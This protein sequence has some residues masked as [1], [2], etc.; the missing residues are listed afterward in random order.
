VEHNGRIPSD[1]EGKA[2][3]ATQPT[4]LPWGAPSGFRTIPSHKGPLFNPD[5]KAFRATTDAE[6][7]GIWLAE[8]AGSNK[9]TAAAYRKEVERLLLWLADQG[10]TLSDASREDYVRF[11]AFLLDPRPAERW[12]GNK[13]LPRSN[14]G[15]R[16]FQAPLSNGSAR[17]ALTICRSLISYL[18]TNG[19]LVANTMPEPKVL[20]RHTA[21]PRPEQIALRQIP[22]SLMAK[23]EGF[24]TAY[25]KQIK[26]NEHNTE[27][28]AIRLRRDFE[29]RRLELIIALAGTMGARSSDLLNAMTSNIVPQHA[30]GTTN[31]IWLLPKG[32]GNKDR[33]LPLP[34]QVMEKIV[35]MRVTLGLTPYPSHNEEPCP[36]IPSSA[37]LPR[38]GNVVRI[39]RLKPLSRSGLYRLMDRFLKSLAD[40]LRAQGDHS[41]AQLLAN[42]SS[43]WFR[44][45]AG[46]RILA[47]S[48]NNLTIARRLLN[49]ASIQTT[50]DYVDA[51]TDE[52][53]EALKAQN[54][55][56]DTPD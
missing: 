47:A 36:L 38:S 44:H 52:L 24:P 40:E 3:Q 48:N 23:I 45:V 5:Q 43:H 51:T 9:N 42:A 8:R 1:G 20:I 14:P 37:N 15:W 11:S 18:H 21:L 10:M 32:K 25:S 30:A 33:S 39:D 49:H 31:W 53:A 35:L 29:R 19:W 26:L 41:G 16:P 34:D 4:T 46:K 6:A 28:E 50:S 54:K 2:I 13:R 22:E 12:I 55:T 7:V 56:T 27:S 17:Q